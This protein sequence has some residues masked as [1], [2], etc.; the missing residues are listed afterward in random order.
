MASARSGEVQI[1]I[2]VR[3]SMTG[4]IK[5]A[6]PGHESESSLLEIPGPKP[7]AGMLAERASMSEAPSGER[8][9]GWPR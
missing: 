9:V 3:C 2:A 5:I 1:T 7:S 4:E 6:D 8:V